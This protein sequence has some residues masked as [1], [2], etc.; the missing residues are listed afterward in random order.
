MRDVTERKQAEEQR[1]QLLARLEAANQE[2]K[3]FAYVI[4]HDL[5]APLRGVSSIAHWLLTE[6]GER[7]DDESQELLNLLAGRVRRMEQMINGVLEYSR[8]GRETSISDGSI[9]RLSPK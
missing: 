5:R 8:I 9:S 7:F 3:D 1:Q 4:S 2:L 6:Y